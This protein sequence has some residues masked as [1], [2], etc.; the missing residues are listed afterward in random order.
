MKLLII[1]LAVSLLAGCAIVPLDPF[2]HHG[3][4]RSYGYSD[5]HGYDRHHDGYGYG[6]RGY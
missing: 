4:H 3:Y 1:A 2:Y 6:H 5:G